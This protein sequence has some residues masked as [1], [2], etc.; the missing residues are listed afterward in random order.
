MLIEI[1]VTAFVVGFVALAAYGHVLVAR[2]MLGRKDGETK[3]ETRPRER[4][5][6][7]G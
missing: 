3:P 5:R 1:I 6:R 7:A 2:A 4:L